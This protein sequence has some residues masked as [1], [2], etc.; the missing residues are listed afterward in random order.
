MLQEPGRALIEN[1]ELTR[2]CNAIVHEHAEQFG[3]SVRQRNDVIRSLRLLQTLL[4][5]PTAKMRASDV[6]QLPRYDGNIVS[7]LDVLDAAGLLI[8][9][10]PRWF[11]TYFTNK[12]SLLPQVMQEQLEV[13]VN[14][15]ID[16]AT[17]TPRQCSRDP[18]TVKVHIHAVVPAVTA[19]AEAGHQSLAEISPTP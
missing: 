1:S 5:S 6:L 15:L 11:D 3:W 10:R 9:D 4:D 2:Y 7:T 12:T 14:V 18:L 17:T 16:G 19:W 13:W 8:D